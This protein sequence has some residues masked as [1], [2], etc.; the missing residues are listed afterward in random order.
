MQDCGALGV[1]LEF[2]TQGSSPRQEAIP[3]APDAFRFPNLHISQ[4]G[5]FSRGNEI[6]IAS[7]LDCAKEL[8]T[9]QLDK[10]TAEV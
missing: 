6:W 8:Q 2:P 9:F 5:N 3:T 7:N 1:D 10:I 4:R